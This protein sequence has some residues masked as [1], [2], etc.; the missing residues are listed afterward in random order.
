MYSLQQS[1]EVRNFGLTETIALGTLQQ[2]CTETW[3]VSP[4]DLCYL[5]FGPLKPHFGH[6]RDQFG[7]DREVL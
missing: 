5:L 4:I 1:C 2:R 7:R 6:V 3:S